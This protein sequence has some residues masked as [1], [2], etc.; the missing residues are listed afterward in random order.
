MALLERSYTKVVF[1]LMNIPHHISTQPESRLIICLPHGIRSALV[2]H[3]QQV[4][5]IINK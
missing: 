4:L 2:Q 1:A 5:N 3:I